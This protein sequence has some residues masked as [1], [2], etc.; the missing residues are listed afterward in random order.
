MVNVST[1][2]ILDTFMD[3]MSETTDI[4]YLLKSEI[5]M[6]TVCHADIED[7]TEED[8]LEGL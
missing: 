1:K 2:Q 5:A 3:C 8:L 6:A 7:L 4:D